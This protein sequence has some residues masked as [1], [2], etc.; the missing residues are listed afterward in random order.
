M[1]VFLMNNIFNIS[2][3]V[4]VAI[5]C[6]FILGFSLGSGKPIKHLIFNALAGLVAFILIKL[7]SRFTGVNISLNQWTAIGASVFGI[8][9]VCFFVLLE[10]IL[11]V[12]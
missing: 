11:S 4:I 8:P 3:L 1:E 6:L 12:L 5:G 2:A 9:A 7:T 10:L